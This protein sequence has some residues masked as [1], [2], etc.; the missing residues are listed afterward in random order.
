MMTMPQA[1]AGA[2]T[3]HP[4]VAGAASSLLSFVQ[5]VLASIAALIVGVAFDGTVRPMATT[6]AVSALLAAA[7]F[8]LLVRPARTASSDDAG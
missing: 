7:A 1:A 2:M 8:V 4:R 6:I 3:P 5:F